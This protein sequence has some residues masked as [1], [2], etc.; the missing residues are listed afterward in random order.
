MQKISKI[1]A[2]EDLDTLSTRTGVV[3]CS[4]EVAEWRQYV[5]L[6]TS[7]FVI[8]DILAGQITG[9]SVAK[10]I[11]SAAYQIEDD[12]QMSK[13]SAK[14]GSKKVVTSTGPGGGISKARIDVDAVT[15]D[16]MMQAES[17]LELLRRAEARKG[18]AEYLR[19]RLDKQMR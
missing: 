5:P 17:S 9:N 1:R 12:D 2:E 7:G 3:T 16:A 11:M 15:A 14:G 4:S 6:I 19:E 18:S 13:G 10:S 8:I